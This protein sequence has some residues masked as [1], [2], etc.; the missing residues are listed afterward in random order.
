MMNKKGN[1][2]DIAEW[3]SLAMILGIVIVITLLWISNFNTQIQGYNESVIPAEAKRGVENLNSALPSGLDILFI[4]MYLLFVAFSVAMARLIPSTPKFMIIA[5]FMLILMPFLAMIIANVWDGFA[6][7][8][9]LASILSTTPIMRFIMDKLV[10]F[11]LF[12]SFAV[13]VALFTKDESNIGSS[14]GGGN[15]L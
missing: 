7:N 9:T 11:V 3:I 13:G 6:S 12:Y 10:Y 4:S 14:G 5:V 15:G 2:P 1:F 8:T